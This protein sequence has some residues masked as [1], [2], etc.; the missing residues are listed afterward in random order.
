MPLARYAA[1]HW[2]SHAQ[3]GT[4]SSHV[5]CMTE[6][7]FDSDKPHFAAWVKTYD[8]D[9]QQYP[10][11]DLAQ[12]HS[13][14][15]YY[16]ALCGFYDVLQHLVS[17][18][19]QYVNALGG[20]YQCPLVAAL[21]GRH[22]RVA[23]LLFQHGAN[24]D[25]RGRKEWTLLHNVI[26]WPENLAVGAV[27]FLL[28]HGAD[29]NARLKDLSTPLHL[30]VDLGRF[31]VAQM[32]LERGVGVN[33]RT[34]DGKTPLHLY[35]AE[36]D[37][38]D[39][40]DQT[41]LHVASSRLD[42]EVSRVLLNNDAYVN[43]EDYRHRTPLH[44]VFKPSNVTIGGLFDTVQL[45]AE[46]GAD[47]NARD[48]DHE[49]P[50]HLASS[51]GDLESVRVL[52]DHGANVNAKNKQGQTPLLRA[53]TLND[54]VLKDRFGVAELLLERGADANAQ[55]KDH[56]SP[57][58]LASWVPDFKLV[59]MLLAHGASANVKDNRGRTPLHQVLKTQDCYDLDDRCSVIVELLVERVAS[60][61]N[62]SILLEHGADINA[63]NKQRKTP[64]QLVREK[65]KEEMELPPSDIR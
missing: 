9:W 27:Q 25:I 33:S 1:K 60:I 56:E 38:R 20:K 45:L 23:E 15:L 36:V 57:L 34:V 11:R 46:R 63:E 55:D 16:S 42:L 58:L 41:A 28:K 4:V 50:L 59:G 37:S 24:I 30:A 13:N 21:H 49:T 5:M 43:A 64:F 7:L 52:L 26:R 54:S 53:S 22:I 10:T 44:Q 32:L 39:K 48:E 3:V 18:H 14:P 62:A 31:E 8:I 17:K 61:K 29:A 65:M 2:V 47:V 6:T 12:D 35:G 19:P 51:H 40:K